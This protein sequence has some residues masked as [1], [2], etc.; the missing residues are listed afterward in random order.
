MFPSGVKFLLINDRHPNILRLFTYFHDT[1]RIFL[2]LEYSIKGELFKHLQ[3]E[4][5]FSEARTAKVSCRY[6]GR[7]VFALFIEPILLLNQQYTYQMA[8]A[9]AYLHKKHVIHRDIKPE[10]ILLGDSDL[11][12]VSS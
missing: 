7:S 12:V 3:R 10:N 1:K 8:D 2:V 9:L 11:T 5:R 6:L 4:G